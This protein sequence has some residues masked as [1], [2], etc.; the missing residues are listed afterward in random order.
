MICVCGEGKFREW[1]RLVSNSHQIW[2]KAFRGILVLCISTHQAGIRYAGIWLLHKV[3]KLRLMPSAAVNS[4]YRS[5][6]KV[7]AETTETICRWMNGNTCSADNQS[8]GEGAGMKG[9]N[10]AKKLLMHLAH[11]YT[12]YESVI[13]H[14]PVAH[15]FVSNFSWN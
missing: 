3:C 10:V 4:G 13:F 7:A 9:S 8:K 5:H 14:E 1:T 15:F 12:R 11:E 6:S 2:K